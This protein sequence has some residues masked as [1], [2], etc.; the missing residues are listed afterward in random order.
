IVLFAR[1]TRTDERSG[2]WWPPSL[3]GGHGACARH[4]ALD[5]VVVP[6]AAAEIA[7]EAL[8]H[9]LLRGARMAACEVERVHHPDR[10]AEA[11]WHVV[12]LLERCLHGMQGSIGT[13]DAFD[14]QDV[15]AFGLHGDDRAALDRS[16][17]QVHG[18]RAAL[19]RVAADMGPGE[20]QVLADER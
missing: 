18:A 16:S 13:R 3:A 7:F 12:V 4:D 19:R 10:G 1:D 15:G 8:A 5:D 20:P 17:V 14:R 6:G 9:F 2:H 11:A